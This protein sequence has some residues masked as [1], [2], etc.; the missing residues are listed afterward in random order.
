MQAL[1]GVNVCENE[2]IGSHRG[3]VRQKILY[4]DPPMRVADPEICTGGQ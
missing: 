1:F 2:R 3:G 4:V